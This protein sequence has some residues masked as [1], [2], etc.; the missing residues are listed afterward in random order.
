MAHRRWKDI[1]WAVQRPTPGIIGWM[2]W[3]TGV[4]F[5]DADLEGSG[6]WP[7]VMQDGSE[8]S[9][10]LMHT[11]SHETLHFL[12]LATMGFMYRWVC[13][14]HRLLAACLS[15]LRAEIAAWLDDADPR[16]LLA[17]EGRID[18]ARR[19]TLGRHLARLDQRGPNRISVRHLLEAHAL[20]AEQKIHWQGLD[21]A[22]LTPLLDHEAAGPE[23]RLA[24]DLT[25]TR[26]GERCAF[27]NFLLIASLALCAEDPP[28]AFDELLD[29]LARRP[30]PEVDDDD[31]ADTDQVVQAANQ[32]VSAFIG[33]SAS[34]L[35][36][37]DRM[38]HPIYTRA[39][40]AIN[41]ACDRG[42]RAI[43]FF[44][45]PHCNLASI[46]DAAIRPTVFRPTGD[47]RFPVIVPKGMS[48]D[49]A[50]DLLLLAVLA[51][52]VNPAAPRDAGAAEDA[53]FAWLAEVG[54]R[55][56]ALEVQP[57]QLHTGDFGGLAALDPGAVPAAMRRDLCRWWGRCALVFDIDDPGPV[58]LRADVRR[59][60][61]RLAAAQPAF[62]VYLDPTPQAD[63]FVVWFGALADPQALPG[64]ALDLMHPSVVDRVM[65]AV[66]AIV[67]LADGLGLSARPAVQRLLTPYPRAQVEA[68]LAALP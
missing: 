59:F 18:P 9:R 43:D 14:H 63:M 8:R 39:L 65:A 46:A 4:Q 13:E 42:W 51:S 23:Y 20:V 67:T 50:T 49:Q 27:R 2:D 17:I 48:D 62:A 3:P 54:S 56:V 15:P 53:R 35:Q 38:R 26:L 45:D 16:K 36:A 57:A 19:D 34:V 37:D 60:I 44:G 30:T 12:Q 31:A 58:W 24:Y 41:A 5:I 21:A 64:H 28:L 66:Q 52:R 68:M 61:A 1:L 7:A 29:A 11:V 25:R 10:Q 22:K 40:A 47:D 55:P 33:T 6:Q 32:A